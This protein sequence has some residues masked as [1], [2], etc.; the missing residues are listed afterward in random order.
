[1]PE[2][3]VI[4]LSHHNINVDFARI[5][6]AGIVGVIHKATQGVGFVDPKYRSRKQPALDSGLLWG[7]YHFGT[8]DD[9][10]EQVNHFLDFVQPDG[11]F[12]LAL[13][14]EKNEP[15]PNNSMSLQQ[16]KTFLTAVEQKTG[17]RPVLYTGSYMN[18]VAGPRADPDLA[19]YRVWWARYSDQ[20]RLH[21]TWQNYFLWQ[22]TDGHHGQATSIPG[23]GSC[24]CNAVTID[25]VTLRGIWTA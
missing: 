15:S 8:N 9:V 17:Q 25:E 4:D 5:R 6:A 7:A 20:P 2:P 13:D 24:D 23:V 1:M 19:N 16:A 3:I 11:N 14:F 18:E 10:G 22:Y 12:L 21:P